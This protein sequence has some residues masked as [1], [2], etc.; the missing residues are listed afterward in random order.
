MHKLCIDYLYK[1]KRQLK[2]KFDP[3][4]GTDEFL[5]Y[6]NNK[7]HSITGYKPI[8]LKDATDENLI[9]NVLNN[10]INSLRRKTK[11]NDSNIFEG[12]FI[13]ITIK[14]CKKGNVFKLKII[15]VN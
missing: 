1:L 2:N 15:K 11:K 4:I 13:L 10:I 8:D 12:A 5:F 14:I 7:K 6:H 3:E 9:K